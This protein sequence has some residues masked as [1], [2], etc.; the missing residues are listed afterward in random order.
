M[1]DLQ[2]QMLTYHPRTLEQSSPTTFGGFNISQLF[3]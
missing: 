3:K 1:E 2:V